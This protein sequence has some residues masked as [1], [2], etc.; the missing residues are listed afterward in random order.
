MT[1][2]KLKNLVP[3]DDGYMNVYETGKGKK[4]IVFLSGGLTSSPILDFKTLFTYLE[5]VFKIVVVEKF[6]Y[7]FSSDTESSRNID[8]ILEN[9]R[10]SLKARGIKPPYVLAP[11]SM[12]GIEAL[13]WYKKY[14]QE[15]SAIVGL[16][17]ATYEAYENL[18]ISLVGLKINRWLVKTK[19]TNLLPKVVESDAIK[20]GNLTR[21]EKDTYKELFYK[22]FPSTATLNEVKQVKRNSEKVRDINL[23]LLPLLILVSNGNGTGIKKNKWFSIQENLRN[24]SRIGKIIYYDC[25]H[26]VHNHKAKEIAEEIKLFLK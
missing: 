9:T 21:I 5:D 8:T 12:S 23:E 22:N 6:G 11:H 20:Y 15:V 19:V 14:P 1:I 25:P 2:N 4:Q 17:M 18:K 16:D 24:K 10:E 26:Y 3:I 7:G 13:Y